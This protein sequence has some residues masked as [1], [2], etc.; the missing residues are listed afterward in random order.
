MVQ[1]VTL[2]PLLL[3]VAFL[4]VAAFLDHTA[5]VF[6]GTFVITGAAENE[7]ETGQTGKKSGTQLASCTFAH[8]RTHTPS[9]CGAN[10]TS[11]ST[12]AQDIRQVRCWGNWRL[13]EALRRPSRCRSSHGPS[14]D[15]DRAEDD[16]LSRTW[17]LLPAQNPTG[18]AAAPGG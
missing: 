14:P 3:D 10:M 16:P 6:D 4:T 7:G 11:P 5:T 15:P 13:Y 12:S 1:A 8:G 18:T 2:T 17:S 9:C